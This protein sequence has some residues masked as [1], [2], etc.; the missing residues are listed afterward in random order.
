M[1]TKVNSGVLFKNDRTQKETDPIYRG[2]FQTDHGKFSLSAWDSGSKDP[3]GLGKGV[4]FE[5]PD[6]ATDKH[7]DMI[8]SINVN[9]ARYA[10]SA[11]RRT[12]SKGNDYMSL[13]LREWANQWQGIPDDHYSLGCQ[14][15]KER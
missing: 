8:G 10:L 6:K 9:G 4:L 14:E 3:S 12:S 11:W 15:W 1:D 7:P 13:A 5:N 2:N